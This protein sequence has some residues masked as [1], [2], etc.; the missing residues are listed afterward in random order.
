M[1]GER[2]ML[3]GKINFGA[4][5]LAVCAALLSVDS[6]TAVPVSV[7][8]EFVL[9]TP[10]PD[11][12]VCWT[13]LIKGVVNK[14]CAKRGAGQTDSNLWYSPYRNCTQV[15][16]DITDECNKNEKLG[17]CKQVFITCSDGGHAINMV[18]NPDTGK[19][20]LLDATRGVSF[21]EAT[22]GF[23]NPKTIPDNLACKVMK[24]PDGCDCKATL[25]INPDHPANTNPNN[26]V[27]TTQAGTT[28][29]GDSTTTPFSRNKSGCNKCC[30]EL[31]KSQKDYLST[32]CGV[33]WKE[34]LPRSFPPSITDRITD[35]TIAAQR[36]YSWF[37]DLTRW[38]VDCK[39]ACAEAFTT[40]IP[41]DTPKQ[42]N[43]RGR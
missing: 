26:C 16:K 34:S 14:C 8:M 10:I 43:R 25:T 9:D 39:K 30:D 31:T 23:T 18:Q 6:A 27:V 12:K 41:I 5:A 32:V 4:M 42:P 2:E 22:D 28:V 17:G 1:F 38:E 35:S 13:E 24:K 11:T 19:Y 36:C 21:L 40:P 20:H 3:M 15:S 37:T 29:D 33:F 7:P